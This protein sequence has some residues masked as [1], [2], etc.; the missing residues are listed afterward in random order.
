MCVLSKGSIKVECGNT[1]TTY[2]STN[3]RSDKNLQ[4]KKYKIINKITSEDNADRNE[5]DGV[6][7]LEVFSAAL[8]QMDRRDWRGVVMLE[9]PGFALFTCHSERSPQAGGQLL[10]VVVPQLHATHSHNLADEADLLSFQ[11]FTS[12]ILKKKMTKEKVR[13]H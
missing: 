10:G 4:G 5:P 8:C 11:V 9:S 3:L 6:L 2:R 1:C 12:Q 13:S 7:T